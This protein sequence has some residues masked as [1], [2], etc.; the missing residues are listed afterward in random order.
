MRRLR[1]ARGQTTTEFAMI[2]GLTVVIATGMVVVMSPTVRETLQQAT[3]CVI[4][5]VC[6]ASKPH[7][8]LRAASVLPSPD[9]VWGLFILRKNW[10]RQKK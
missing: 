7:F 4:S 3:E 8:A 6:S 10:P 5:D 2:V 1:G 9:T